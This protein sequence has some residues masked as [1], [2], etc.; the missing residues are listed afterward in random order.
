MQR[1]SIARS[2]RLALLGLTL[3]LAVVAAL[4]VSSLYDARQRYEDTLAQSSA[5]AT[6]GR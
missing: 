5:L 1:L 6:A 3:I 2:L 4:G